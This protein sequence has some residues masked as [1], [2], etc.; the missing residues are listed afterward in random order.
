M[1]NDMHKYFIKTPWIVKQIFSSYVWNLSPNEHIVYLTFDDGP[2]PE[3]TPWVLDL[4]K[5]YNAHATF[6]CIGSN[7]EQYPEVYQRILNEDHVVGNHTYDHI[8]GWKTNTDK[9]IADVDKASAF[10]KSNLFRPPYGKITTKQARQIP[11]ALQC[12]DAKIIMWDVLSADFDT[13]YSPEECLN[14]VVKNVTDGSIIV[15]HDSEKA[16]PNLK[17]SL[18]GSLEYLK[19]EG[20]KLNKIEL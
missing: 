13:N 12:T 14:N 4:L 19:K 18:L 17:Y 1:L 15:F 3:V 8:N 20:Y 2:D 16:F 10:I 7:V 5:Q 6:F 11:S 9:Y